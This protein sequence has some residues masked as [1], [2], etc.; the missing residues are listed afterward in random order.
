MGT[1]VLLPRRTLREGWGKPKWGKPKWG[2]FL[3][4][5]YVYG[6]NFRIVDTMT[7]CFS[8][9]TLSMYTLDFENSF[10]DIGFHE[11][12]RTSARARIRKGANS[13][14]DIDF[15][16][17]PMLCLVPCNLSDFISKQSPEM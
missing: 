14:E 16:E 8:T 12:V 3:E 5:N 6:I 9:S 2:K 10:Q 11:Y 13:F 17:C 7:S 15:H 1:V 4:L